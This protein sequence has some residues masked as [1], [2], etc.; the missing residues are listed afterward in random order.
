VNL[1]DSLLVAAY[2][3]GAGAWIYGG[4]ETDATYHPFLV[5][6][7]VVALHALMGAAVGRVWSL[8]LPI[9][10]IPIAL[11]AGHAGH[12][13][14]DLSRVW[15]FVLIAT[16]FNVGGTALGYVV[17]TKLRRRGR[18]PVEEATRVTRQ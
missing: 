15:E 1:R 10:L 16:P 8:L 12:E 5:F 14:G 9:L 13:T 18:T 3:A 7:A 11:P 2:A 6:V 17:A 4:L